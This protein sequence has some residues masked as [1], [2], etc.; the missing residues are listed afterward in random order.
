V[1][2]PAAHVRS[3]HARAHAGSCPAWSGQ[4]RISTPA[5]RHLTSIDRHRGVRALCGSILI[6]TAVISTLLRVIYRG[7]GDRGGRA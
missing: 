1:P 7:N 5:Q 2:P 4:A 3:G 6:I